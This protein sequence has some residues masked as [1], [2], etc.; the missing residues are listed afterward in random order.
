M[1]QSLF[2]LNS[3]K[4]NTV[5]TRGM[6]TVGGQETKASLYPFIKRESFL[7]KSSF[8]KQIIFLTVKKIVKQME[9]IRAV[10]DISY[11]HQSTEV[12]SENLATRV[13]ASWILA[14]L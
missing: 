8:Y 4:D 5:A 7:L 12:V 11:H 3:T 14:K 2:T 10:I 1:T 9:S 13:V 6:F